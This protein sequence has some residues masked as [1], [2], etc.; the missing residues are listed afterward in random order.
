MKLRILAIVLLAAFAP[1]LPALELSGGVR[2][3]AGGSFLYGDWIENLRGELTDLGAATVTARPYFTW[4]LGGWVEMPVLA[5]LSV[6]VEPMLGLVGGALLASDGY[7][8]LAGVWE[9]ELALP[10]LVTTAIALPV[11]EIVLGAGPLVTVALPVMQTWNDGIVW[12]DQW[13]AIVLASFGAAGGLGYALPLGPGS[14]TF[15]LRV[16]ASFLSL[17]AP[18]MDGML[19]AVSVELTAGWQFGS[20][21]TP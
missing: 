9:L 21:G 4:R 16:L 13:L 6:R 8:L 19:N 3:G 20:R 5:R 7:D 1:G 17:A 2:L 12:Y 18:S 11:G 14:L 10:V 15:D